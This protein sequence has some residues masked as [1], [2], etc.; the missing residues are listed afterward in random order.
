MKDN[1][2]RKETRGLLHAAAVNITMFDKSSQEYKTNFESLVAQLEALLAEEVR[3]AIEKI[4]QENTVN[5][6]G[7]Q[8]GSDISTKK[9]WVKVIKTQD[10]L[11]LPHFNADIFEGI[12]GITVDDCKCEDI[13][14]DEITINGKKYR[15]V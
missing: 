8:E 6:F 7:I 1:T 2:L 9:K 3:K 15:A 13:N 10:I 11:D 5:F 12:T 14:V 4:A